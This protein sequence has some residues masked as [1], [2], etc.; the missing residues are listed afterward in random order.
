MAIIRSE[1]ELV[2]ACEGCTLYGYNVDARQGTER[3]RAPSTGVS[4][5]RA[6]LLRRIQMAKFQIV[7]KNP[8]WDVNRPA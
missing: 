7:M 1:T 5:L 6:I 4:V 2:G 3:N 8:D